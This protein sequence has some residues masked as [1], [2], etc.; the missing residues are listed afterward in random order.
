MEDL[1]LYLGNGIFGFIIGMFLRRRNIKVKFLSNLQ[2]IAIVLMVFFMGSRMG[3]NE[4]VIYNLG[5]IGL[6]ALVITVLSMIFSI[7]LLHVARRIMKMNK[8]G[9]VQQEISGSS[10][11]NH[12]TNKGF[13]VD[14][15]T[16][17]ILCSVAAGIL[18]GYVLVPVF[19]ENHETFDQLA[20]KLIMWLLCLLLILVGVDLG[21]DENIGKNF[22]SAGLRILAF[23]VVTA[24]GTLSGAAVC[25]LFLPISIKEAVAVG[26]GFGWYTLAPGIIMEAG[27]VTASAVSFMHNI[28]REL[29]SIIFIP[30]V[31]RKIGYAE[32]TCMPGAAAMD[33][34]LPI[35]ERSTNGT[36]AIYSF[37]SGLTLS[38][39]VPIIVPIICNL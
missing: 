9:L 26:A 27:M 39:A 29:L 25:A 37:I 6:Y 11:E 23:P 13:T 1:L 32:T 18:G 7:A 33:V 2:T 12:G 20:A 14:K 36:V 30:V 15:M 5:S 10:S 34:C 31:A 8:E 22:R 35:V 38:F 19:F 4:K 21:G 16:V 24:V 3:A 28:L 17:F